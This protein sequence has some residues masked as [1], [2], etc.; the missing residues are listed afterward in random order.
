MGSPTLTPNLGF[1]IPAY[2]ALNWNVAMQ[3]NWQLLDLMLSG[4]IQLPA[5]NVAN[6][7]AGIVGLVAAQITSALGFTP[8]NP[9]NNLAD[10]TNTAAAL[11]NIGGIGT[12]SV[13]GAWSSTTTYNAGNIVSYN[14]A[15]YISKLGPQ[16]NNEPDSSP[17]YWTLFLS[18]TPVTPYAEQPAGAYPGTVYT[19]S[20]TPISMMGVFKNGLLLEPTADYTLSGTSV[21]LTSATSTGDVVFAVYL[22]SSGTA[23]GGI[24]NIQREIPAGTI[25]GTNATFTTT[26]A[27]NP[28]G[29]LLVIVNGVIQAQANYTLTGNTITFSSGSIPHTGATLETW[30]AH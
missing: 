13:L 26:Y 3:Y 6:L 18:S 17:T 10:V 4:Q 1:Q 29:S 2:G 7:T 24:V 21:T 5:L 14:G 23:S 15:S 8:L 30:Y 27:P 11:A 22:K 12:G 25:N 28:V 19:L 9:A 16:S 20:Y